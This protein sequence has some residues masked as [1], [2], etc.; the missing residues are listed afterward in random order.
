MSPGSESAL[1]VAFGGTRQRRT[2]AIL[3]GLAWFA[4]RK[5]LGAL[6]AI[7]LVLIVI[8]GA[9]APWIARDASNVSHLSD[10]FAAPGR[11]YWFGTDQNGRDIF[12]RIVYGCQVTAMVGLGTVLLVG[13]LSLSIG[14]VSGYF[15]G[16]LDL[17]VQRFVDMWLSFPAVFLILT[18]VAVL[19]VS[20]GPGFL[21]LG[22]GPAFG[23]DPSAGDWPWHTLPRTTIVVLSLGLVLAGGA[24]RVIRSAVI[25]TRSSPYVEAARALGAS[26]ARIIRRHILPNTLPTAIVL[27]T[28]QMGTAILAEATI[29]F[30]GVGITNFPTWGQML[31]G[32][33][34]VFAGSH[35]Y[36]VIFPGAAIFLAVFGFNMLGDA[37][38]DVLDPRLRGSR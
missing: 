22:R 29:S 20:S 34:R 5:P 6:G 25:A 11:E 12:S 14:L 9:F 7:L 21:G 24:S 1:G 10:Q 4:R 31:S 23:P 36:I 2:V 30:L 8:T 3:G 38:S 35:P 15:G 26:D 32:Q 27:A 37:L 13:A 28:V 16:R 17:A 18:M 19:N 33:A